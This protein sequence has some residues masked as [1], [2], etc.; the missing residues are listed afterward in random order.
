MKQKIILPIFF[1]MMLSLS[2]FVS[3]TIDQDI[4]GVTFKSTNTENSCSLMNDYD[5][6]LALNCEQE[7]ADYEN[8]EYAIYILK[9]QSTFSKN[10]YFS[11]LN[12]LPLESSD[13]LCESDKCVLYLKNNDVFFTTWLSGKNAILLSTPLT[14]DDDFDSQKWEML[15]G[16]YSELYPTSLNENDAESFEEGNYQDAPANDEQEDVEDT[17]QIVSKC[18]DSDGG[19]NPSILGKAEIEGAG[20]QGDWCDYSKG[21]NKIYEAYCINDTAYTTILMDCPTDKPYCNKG[22]CS[23]NKAQCTEDDGGKNPLVLGTTFPSRIADHTGSTD[24][25][26]ITSTGQPPESGEC[27]GSDCSLREFFCVEGSPDEF[28][29]DI[30]C[31]SGCKNGVCSK[32][33]PTEETGPIEIVE[34]TEG[35]KEEI[36]VV[37]EDCNGCI[38]DKKCYPIGY[39]MENTYCDNQQFSNQK[40]ADAS[41]NNNFECS[42]NLCIDNECVSSGFW[43]KIMRFFKN[44]FG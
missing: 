30:P 28:Y 31:P 10:N 7:F 38:L 16:A 12:T 4:N 8:G 6:S 24:Y 33:E 42:T 25:C 39:R 27:S 40:E 43:Q 34:E 36:K 35:V 44:L 13:F 29:N 17:P 18:K 21:E 22:K 3:A 9:V 19:K 32:I 14:T 37:K 20:G 5:S 15:L 1:L 11:F 26:Q 23:A 2:V 41:C